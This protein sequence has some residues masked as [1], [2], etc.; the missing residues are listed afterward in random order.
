MLVEIMNILGGLIL[1]ASILSAI[2]AVGEYMEGFALWLGSFKVLIGIIAILLALL[3]WS[4]GQSVVAILV[5]LI[6]VIGI[7]PKI[8][9]LGEYLYRFA[10]WLKSF[11]VIIGIVAILVG[12][13]GLV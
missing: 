8:P 2:P 11:Q 4:R 1:C 6:L 5:G 7:L 10:K 12:I 3:V 13:A 9:A